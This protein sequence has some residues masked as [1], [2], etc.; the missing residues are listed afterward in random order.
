MTDNTYAKRPL[1]QWIVV[2][3]VIGGV[4]YAGVY[5]LYL[6]KRGGYNNQSSQDQA[7]QITPSNQ[8]MVTIQNMSFSPSS[9]TIK[10]G[11]TVTWT[12]LDSVSHTST[13]DDNS[14]DT[15]TLSTGQSKTITFSKAGT[16]TYHCTIHPG[17]KGTIVVQ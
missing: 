1:W 17:M 8:N 15:G 7:Q 4:I 13:A 14:F 5:Y 10:T 2:Y 16:Y 11:D 9:M 6:S 3:L 12:D